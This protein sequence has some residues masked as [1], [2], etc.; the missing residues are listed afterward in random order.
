MPGADSMPVCQGSGST[1]PPHAQDKAAVG[2]SCTT[3]KNRSHLTVRVC[4][5]RIATLCSC[6]SLAMKRLA[7]T[8][9]SGVTATAGL[10]QLTARFR[11]L[12]DPHAG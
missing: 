12:H 6:S 4:T 7:L 8:T 5:V 3:A 9:R 1:T 11:S 10:S 2:G